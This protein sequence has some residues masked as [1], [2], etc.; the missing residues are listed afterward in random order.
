MYTLYYTTRS[1]TTESTALIAR[2]ALEEADAAYDVIEVE[3][4]P[5]PPAWFL[6][7]NPNGKIPALEVLSTTAKGSKYAI[8]PSPAILLALADRHPKAGLLPAN[9]MVRANCYSTLLD[10]VETLHSA[11]NRAFFTERYSTGEAHINSIRQ[12]AKS[13]IAAYFQSIETHL[14]D[15]GAFVSDQFTLCDIYLYVMARW[16]EDLVPG[17]DLNPL[18]SLKTFPRL[19]R[20]IAQ[21]ERRPAVRRAL[22]ADDL[23]PLLGKEVTLKGDSNV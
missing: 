12:K 9:E 19:S 17:N 6:D 2:I 4:D 3:L 16:Y 1:Y 18:K 10:M 14:S 7:I 22:T 15:S 8:H 13:G 20:F 11:F 5:S 21:T 23:L